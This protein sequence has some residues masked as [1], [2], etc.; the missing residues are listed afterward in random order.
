MPIRQTLRD[1]LVQAW[2]QTIEQPYREQLINSE[3]GLQVH[4]CAALLN[5]FSKYERPR[6]IFVEPRISSKLLDKGYIP[7]VL[8]C[9]Q[10][11]IIGIVELK[12]KPKG[13]AKYVKD[14]RTLERLTDQEAEITIANDRFRGKK[15]NVR[16]YKMASNSIVCWAAVYSGKIIQAE[17]KLD[18][19][20]KN[21][22]LFL[23]ALTKAGTDPNVL[24]ELPVASE[25]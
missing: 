18:P 19:Q 17:A 7:D 25:P 10:R 21:R 23:H 3:R 5:I 14:L 13:R 22:V 15:L 2:H 6:R 11:S 8:I 24:P 12:Y 4:F 1:Q 16:S 9:N 20:L